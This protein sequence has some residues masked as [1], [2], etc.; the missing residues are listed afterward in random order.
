MRI[1][2]VCA[3]PGVPVFGTKGCS[4]HVQ[5]V[6]RVLVEKGAEVHLFALRAGGMCPSDLS[7]LCVHLLPK[8]NAGSG[9]VRERELLAVNGMLQ[10]WLSLNGP[11]D[12]VYERHALWTYAAMEHAHQNGICGALEVNAPLIEEQIVHRRLHSLRSARWAANRVFHAATQ[13]VAVSAR[14]AD[15]VAD[16]GI[17]ESQISIVPNGVRV[18]RF[19]PQSRSADGCD[20]PFTIGFLGTLKP[21]HGVADLIEAVARLQTGCSRCIARLRIVG[22]GPQR[23]ALEE[24]VARLPKSVQCGIE[25]LGSIGYESVPVELAQWDVAVAPYTLMQDCYFSPLKLFEYMAAGLPVVAAR[26]GQ[27]S[28]MIRHNENGLLYPPGDIDAL[29]AELYELHEDVVQRDR[30][31]QAARRDVEQHH[32]W[33]QRVD[34]ILSNCLGSGILDGDTVA[35][36]RPSRGNQAYV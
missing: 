11:F 7:R 1:A 8:P 9:P 36:L 3:D 2:Y 13:I 26:T 15:Y 34:Q 28:D 32:T 24:Q 14:V 35:S 5:E 22:D 12:F 18:E 27:L 16:F 29:V 25:F 31:A 30:L 4:I 6:L 33:R 20:R 23:Q 21:W 19:V 17:D 10:E